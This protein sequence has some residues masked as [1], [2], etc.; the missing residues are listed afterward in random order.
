[1]LQL[2]WDSLVW[3][4]VQV[5]LILLCIP[6]GLSKYWTKDPEVQKELTS[7]GND[8]PKLIE[9]LIEVWD[10]LTTCETFLLILSLLKMAYRVG[11]AKGIF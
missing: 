11:V 8:T 6:V 5:V 3:F 2:F 10:L 1:M 9:N 4:P 7:R